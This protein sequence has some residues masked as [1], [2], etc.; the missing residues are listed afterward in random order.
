MYAV[1]YRKP[2]EA[3]SELPGYYPEVGGLVMPLMIG[4]S[5]NVLFPYIRPKGGEVVRAEQAGQSQQRTEQKSVLL[6][7]EIV[8]RFTSDGDLVVDP[9]GGTLA[10][11]VAAALRGRRA[12]VVEKDAECVRIAAAH[13]G[14]LLFSPVVCDQDDD[15]DDEDDDIRES[16]S[17]EKLVQLSRP[18]SASL[19]VSSCR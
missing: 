2:A 6:G 17:S 19:L 5:S 12:I 16:V 14:Q 10:F 18:A 9:F 7:G 11:G 1:V 3:E 8:E 15:S 4:G 13:W